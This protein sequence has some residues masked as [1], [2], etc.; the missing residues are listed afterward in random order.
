M[1]TGEH[2]KGRK[3]KYGSDRKHNLGGK[4]AIYD[5]KKGKNSKPQHV[6]LEKDQIEKKIEAFKKITKFK[7][8]DERDF[9]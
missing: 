5:K 3:R 2:L 6:T 1:K 7:L 9:V 4:S 8:N